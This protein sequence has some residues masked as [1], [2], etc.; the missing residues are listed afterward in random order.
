MYFL[1]PLQQSVV[2]Y[3][4]N[5]SCQLNFRRLLQVSVKILAHFE[6]I[7]ANFANLRSQL[8]VNKTHHFQLT[9]KILINIQR[10]LTPCRISQQSK[11]QLLS[12]LRIAYFSVGKKEFKS[13]NL[14][15]FI[16]CLVRI[17]PKTFFNQVQI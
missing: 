5:L 8:S 13:L 3:F 16:I 9:V 14:P 12:T 15:L 7:L 10:Q 17:T 6:L 4:R 2:T 11:F 1:E